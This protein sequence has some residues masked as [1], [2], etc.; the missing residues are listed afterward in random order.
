MQYSTVYSGT[1]IIG[2]TIRTILCAD[3]YVGVSL[4]S[5]V[6]QRAIETFGDT[7]K[8]LNTAVLEVQISRGFPSIINSLLIGGSSGE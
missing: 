5:G 6:N 2:H 8:V 1:F 7:M 4:I 3:F